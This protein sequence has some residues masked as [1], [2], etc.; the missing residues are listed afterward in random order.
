MLAWI[1]SRGCLV[2]DPRTRG[3]GT[4]LTYQSRPGLQVLPASLSPYLEHPAFNPEFSNPGP[5]LPSPKGSSL[6]NTHILVPLSSFSPPFSSPSSPLPLPPLPLSPQ[7]LSF[8]FLSFSL[9]MP[10][11]SAYCTAIWL[12]LTHF[13]GIELIG[14]LWE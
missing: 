2:S 10:N 14:G 11:K 1:R 4:Y 6:Y 5:G 7:K 9:L 12:E 13:T 8:F 3:S